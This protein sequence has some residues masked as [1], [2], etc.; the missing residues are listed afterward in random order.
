[1]DLDGGKVE[2]LWSSKEINARADEYWPLVLDIAQKNNINRITSCSQIMGRSDQ[3]ELTVLSAQVFYPCMQ[4][5][6]VFFL[7]ADICQLGMDQ[8]EVNV[9]AREYCDDIKRKNKPIILSH[10]MLPGLQQVQEKVIQV[11][12]KGK[13]RCQK[14]IHLLPFSRKMRSRSECEDKEGILPSTDS[15]RKPLFG[16]H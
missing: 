14:V 2:F 11:Y 7:K 8:R 1:M 9:L 13:K 6:D 12:S 15:G 4:C 10:H 3:D 5:A 16:A